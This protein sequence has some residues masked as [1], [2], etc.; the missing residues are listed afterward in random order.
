M[1]LGE[2]GAA[3]FVRLQGSGNDLRSLTAERCG[4]AGPVSI[5]AQVSTGSTCSATL[6]GP[7]GAGL[8]Q[9]TADQH[10][11]GS[12]ADVLRWSVAAGVVGPGSVVRVACAPTQR[13]DAP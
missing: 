4:E 8:Y 6:T 7:N 9:L 5:T 11:S 3:P 12:G 2:Q 10:W 13:A 1:R